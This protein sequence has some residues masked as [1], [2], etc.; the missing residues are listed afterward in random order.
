MQAKIK[1]KSPQDDSY[2]NSYD[3]KYF[4]QLLLSF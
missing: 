4:E 2:T 3:K 1:Q